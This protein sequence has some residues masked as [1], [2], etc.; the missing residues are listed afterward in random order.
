MGLEGSWTGGLA[1]PQAAP[2]RADRGGRGVEAAAP[3]PALALF[4][5]EVYAVGLDR[6]IKGHATHYNNGNETI[7]YTSRL[8][9]ESV[10]LP[11]SGIGRETY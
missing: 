8:Y 6:D 5:Q 2:A 1:A 7:R 11:H 3:A 10:C 9:C 4:A